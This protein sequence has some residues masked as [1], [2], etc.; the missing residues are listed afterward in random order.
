MWQKLSGSEVSGSGP[1]PYFEFQKIVIT[2]VVHSRDMSLTQRSA[3]TGTENALAT[4]RK[5]SRRV[6]GA[7][8]VKTARKGRYYARDASKNRKEKARAQTHQTPRRIQTARQRGQ[9]RGSS[10]RGSSAT[11]KAHP[12]SDR[13]QPR[14]RRLAP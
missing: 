12:A 1:L 9:G 5:F 3:K 4:I 11:V 7:G 6:Q 8:L 10:G 13:E 14:P 2:A